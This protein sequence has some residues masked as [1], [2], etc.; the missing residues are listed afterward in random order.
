MRAEATPRGWGAAILAA[1]GK[2][3]AGKDYPSADEADYA[4]HAK[5]FIEGA[6]EMTK[7]G[8]AGDMPAF[9]N[10]R[11]RVQKKCD[12]CHSTYRF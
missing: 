10:A 9:V 6:V 12:E 11:D 4:A 2:V 7:S 3:I 1:L 5:S 8:T